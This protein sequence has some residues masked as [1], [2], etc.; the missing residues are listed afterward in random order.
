[1]AK[2]KTLFMELRAEFFV[3]PGMPVLLAGAIAWRMTGQVNWLTLILT[4]IAAML[5]NGGTNTANDYWDHISQNDELNKNFIRPFTGGSR[6]IQTGQ[7]TAREVLGLTFAQFAI[8]AAIGVYL[9]AVSGWPTLVI[10]AFGI[11]SGYFYTAK[12]YPIGSTGFGELI[13]GIDCA[14][15]VCLAAFYIQTGFLSWA[16]VVASLPLTFIVALILFVNEFPDYL[17]DKAVGKRH[18][19]VRFGTLKMARAHR[20][21]VLLPHL[22]LLAGILTG[23]MPPWTALGFI[24]LP[25][26]L[27]ASANLNKNYDNPKMLVPTSAMTVLSQVLTGI[28][29]CVGYLI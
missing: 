2:I 25:L 16:P 15:L 9:V 23:I 26:L 17:A 4:L 10:G 20:F 5:V 29:L 6:F 21:F 7:L 18:L 8:A 13:A 1:M 11:I 19:V 27:M 14:L 24:S 28:A 3:A 22:S 12:P